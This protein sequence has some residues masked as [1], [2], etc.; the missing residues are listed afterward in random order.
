MAG[1]SL[2][3]HAPVNSLV[4][5]ATLRYSAFSAEGPLKMPLDLVS[6]GKKSCW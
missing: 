4:G 2:L 3:G 1:A 5:G 6:L